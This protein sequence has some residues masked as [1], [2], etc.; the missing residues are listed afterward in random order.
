MLII[1][2]FITETPT[3]LKEIDEIRIQNVG[4]AGGGLHLYKIR[5]P[6]LQPELDD[7]ITHLQVENW[8]VLAILALRKIL[9]SEALQWAED[10]GESVSKELEE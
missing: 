8:K 9:E 10:F 2:A 7:S 1:K 6:D 3:K 4:Y 5:Q